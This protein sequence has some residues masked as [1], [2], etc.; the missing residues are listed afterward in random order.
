MPDLTSWVRRA[1]AVPI[2]RE[3]ERRSTKLC[4][5]TERVGP[6]PKWG[7]NDRFNI[8]IKKQLWNCRGCNVGGDVIKLVE[9]LDD[10]DFLAAYTTLTGEPPPKAKANGK[11]HDATETRKVV[12]AVFPYLDE[13]GALAF[14]SE[15]I[16]HHKADGNF[17][18]T[19]DSK[20]KKT[21]RQKRPDP[22]KP[23]HWILNADGVPIIPYRLPELIEAI[24]NE[25]MIIVVEG[26]AKVDLLWKWNVPA[27]CCAGG[28]KK[29]K[30][31]HSE[32]LRG[33]NLVILPDNDDVG[34]TH[35]N[36]VAASLQGI[37]ASVRVLELTRTYLKI[38]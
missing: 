31:E 29:W 27:T 30:P 35:M 37:A 21:F 11:D 16:E 38:V 34:R 7:G 5:K 15:R 33:A 23:G 2:E 20:H 24:A 1:R 6:C 32:F 36:I 22:E 26:E 9:H 18:L 28:A 25:R 19:K 3:I 12:V 4:G 8:H 10:V 17:V 14:A 13:F